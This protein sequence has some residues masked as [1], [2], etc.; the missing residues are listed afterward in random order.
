MF[1]TRTC[2]WSFRSHSFVEHRCVAI[3]LPARQ[4]KPTRAPDT[5]VPGSSVCRAAVPEFMRVP[6][7]LDSSTNLSRHFTY[8]RLPI[9]RGAPLGAVFANPAIPVD[10]N[11]C[12]AP[13]LIANTRPPS[14]R[15]PQREPSHPPRPGPLHPAAQRL[16]LPHAGHPARAAPPGLGDLPPHQPQAHRH[17][18]APEETVDGWHFY[19][20]PAR[21][22]RPA[23]ARPGRDAR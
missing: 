6:F 23:P 9:T 12:A 14:P 22:Q 2:C 4:R 1:A 13:R 15:R 20:T 17:P 11:S 19:R 16:H 21:R 3:G 10:L 5:R 18:A 7:P 8:H